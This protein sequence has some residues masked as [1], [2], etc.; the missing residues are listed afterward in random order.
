MRDPVSVRLPPNDGYFKAWN[1]DQQLS[2]CILSH[3]PPGTK[4]ADIAVE[5][6]PETDCI[7]F[8]PATATLPLRG[9][10]NWVDCIGRVH[11]HGPFTLYDS[12]IT[13]TMPSPQNDE[14]LLQSPSDKE[15]KECC[16]RQGG[17]CLGTTFS[18]TAIVVPG[19]FHFGGLE[20]G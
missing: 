6:T 2:Y 7:A 9:I 13:Y 1:V 11:V 3:L 17:I 5:I 14:S 10:E 16:E 19:S 15:C 18:G 8:D 20:T 4:P 12:F